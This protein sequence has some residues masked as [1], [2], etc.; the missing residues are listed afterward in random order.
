MEACH[1]T[2]Q[3]N[4]TAYGATTVAIITLEAF[5]GI[6]KRTMQTSSMKDLSM[7]AH[8]RAMKSVLSFLVMYSI[9]F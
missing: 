9:N 2:Q 6:H 3:S 1:P 4:V 7:D 8:I 5:A